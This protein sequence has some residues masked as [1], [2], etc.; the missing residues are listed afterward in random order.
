MQIAAYKFAEGNNIPHRF[1]RTNKIAGASWLKGFCQRHKITLRQPEKCAMGR[2]MGF[3]KVQVNRFYENLKVLLEKHQYLPS[4]IYNMDESGISTV[5]NKL[6]K[7]LASKGKKLVGKVSSADRG[8]LVTVVCCVSA[9][10]TYIPPAMIFSRKRMK[11][12]LFL[13]A[14]TGTYKMI[15]FWVY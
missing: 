11:E 4:S 12:E 3:N 13:N 14:P 15:R 10:G 8:Q 1:S 7:V 9:T 5:P 2:L 6:P